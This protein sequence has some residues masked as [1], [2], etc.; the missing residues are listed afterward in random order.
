MIFAEV[1]LSVRTSYS[2]SLPFPTSPFPTPHS[3]FPYDSP[4]FGQDATS[5]IFDVCCVVLSRMIPY[6]SSAPFTLFEEA[7]LDRRPRKAECGFH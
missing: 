4:L 3:P 1:V 7:D 6:L 5:S 2:H